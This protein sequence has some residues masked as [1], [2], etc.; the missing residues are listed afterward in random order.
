MSPRTKRLSLTATAALL[1]LSAYAARIWLL[2]PKPPDINKALLSECLIFA[3]GDEFNRMFES[4]RR[5]YANALYARIAKLPLL[6]I[7]HLILDDATR[8]RILKFQQNLRR[9]PNSSAIED[10][11]YCL[12]L[13]R[14]YALP[15]LGQRA[16][17]LATA[18]MIEQPMRSNPNWTNRPT[19]DQV[20]T[21]LLRYVQ[22]YPPH[23]QAL[24]C[25]FALDVRKQRESLGLN[26]PMTK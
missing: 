17:I 14:F 15:P 6:E 9:L 7:G 23:Y 4:H 5:Q 21:H 13:D 11:F 22:N 1:L 16:I 24:A 12:C 26:D 2:Y 19:D 10:H 18:L 8:W 3:S 20:A 25:K